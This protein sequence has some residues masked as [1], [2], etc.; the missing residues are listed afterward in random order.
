MLDQI[1]HNMENAVENVDGA[2]EQLDKTV[3]YQDSACMPKIV[4]GMSMIIILLVVIFI[5]KHIGDLQKT[6]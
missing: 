4:C 5:V 6:K 1:D 2:N 3:E